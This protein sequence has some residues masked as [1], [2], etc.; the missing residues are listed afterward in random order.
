MIVSSL[1]FFDSFE[2]R[3]FKDVT[4]LDS[5]IIFSVDAGGSYFIIML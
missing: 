1:N 3:L 5:C 4:T 2:A